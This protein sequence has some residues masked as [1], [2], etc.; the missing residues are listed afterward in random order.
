MQPRVEY[1]RFLIYRNDVHVIVLFFSREVGPI[2]GFGTR[3]QILP[4]QPCPMVGI[5]YLL[6]IML[7]YSVLYFLSFEMKVIGRICLFG[8]K[9]LGIKRCIFLLFAKF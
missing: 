9:N 8:E 5:S 1:V 6:V 4:A 7:L 3:P 2:L